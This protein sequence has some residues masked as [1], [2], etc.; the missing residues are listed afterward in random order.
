MH[1]IQIDK[2]SRED[3]NLHRKTA[4]TELKKSYVSVWCAHVY[5]CVL[6]T[7]VKA[8]AGV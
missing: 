3:R 7:W 5:L 4:G 1:V 8:E 2:A 6:F